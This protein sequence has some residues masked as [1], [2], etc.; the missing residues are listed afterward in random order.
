M[1]EEITEREEFIKIVGILSFSDAHPS[2][3]KYITNFIIDLAKENQQLKEKHYL[4]QG[5]RGNCK[6]YLLKLQEE[7]KQLKEQLDKATRVAL[8]EQR[9]ASKCEDRCINYQSVLDE[10]REYINT[11]TWADLTFKLYLTENEVDEMREILDKV[12]E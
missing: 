2:D 6:T 11:H 5:G 7:N 4:I 3:C 12:K 8:S 10:I 1:S 9:W